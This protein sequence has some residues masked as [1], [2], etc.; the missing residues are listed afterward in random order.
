MSLHRQ[1]PAEV[2]GSHPRHAKIEYL[3]RCL[4]DLRDF[5]IEDRAALALE[6]WASR[7]GDLMGERQ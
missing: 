2:E 7:E 3:K 6:K 1:N 5:R 4:Q